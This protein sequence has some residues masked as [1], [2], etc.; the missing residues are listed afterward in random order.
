MSTTLPV[1]IPVFLVIAAGY[2]ATWR[3]LISAG[4]IDGLM[5][6]T[7]KVAIPCLLFRA[8]AGLDLS[9]AF[10]PRLLGAFYA[11]A[12]S[13][14][15]LGYLAARA[16]FGRDREDAVA[17]G[18]AC[19]FS[20]SVL[21]GLP[22]MERAFGA[23]A[24]AAN[25][26]IIA[27]HSPTCYAVGIT[28]M[29]VA[30]AR[31]DGSALSALPGKV[32]RAMLSN[33]LIVGIGLGLAVNLTGAALP[34]PLMD[35]VD[36][37]VRAALPAALFGLGGVLLRYRPEGSLPTVA[38]VGAISL[39]LHPAITYGLGTAWGLSDAALRSAVVTAAMAPGVNAYIFADI[40]DRGRRVAASAVLLATLA[41][42][43]TV[44]AWL[45][46]LP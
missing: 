44:P 3:G 16:L 27:I 26:A 14:F 24:L 36:M 37:L 15:A 19:L 23:D 31:A 35:A 30:R 32:A 10:D 12:L 20:N 7:Q 22:I 9:A 45:A 17:I 2:V 46:V 39:G 8:V 18:F 29:E 11:G 1:V 5:A 13:G 33:A 40:Y 28:A 43:L 21:I 42:V 6:F 41:S 34:A 4:G 25:F 38:C